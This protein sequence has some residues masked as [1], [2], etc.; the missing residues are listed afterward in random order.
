MTEREQEL[1]AFKAACEAKLKQQKA[2]MFSNVVKLIVFTI[3]AAILKKWW[4]F[5]FVLL[6]WDYTTDEDEREDE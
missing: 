6:F 2:I 1:E 4:V 3:F 5:L